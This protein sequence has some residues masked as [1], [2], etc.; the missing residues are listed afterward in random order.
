MVSDRTRKFAFLSHIRFE[1]LKALKASVIL[2]APAG[3]WLSAV[4]EACD[5]C[6]WHL[7]PARVTGKFFVR[8]RAACFQ[9]QLFHY[10]PLRQTLPGFPLR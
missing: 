4:Y 10:G 8:L 2:L 5:H 9:L 6:L 1:D 7:G 3:L